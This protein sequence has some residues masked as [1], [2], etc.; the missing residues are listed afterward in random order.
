MAEALLLK[1]RSEGSD[2]FRVL[3]NARDDSALRQIIGGQTGQDGM[4]LSRWIS[5]LP[6]PHSACGRDSVYA[7]SLDEVARAVHERWYAG[8]RATIVQAEKAGDSAKAAQLRG[9]PAYKPW[10]EL[11]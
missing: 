2:R 9:K 8:N 6:P 3:I 1:E 11:T 7:E 4:H 10:S 5:F